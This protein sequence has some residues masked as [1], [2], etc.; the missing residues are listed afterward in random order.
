MDSTGEKMKDSDAA[1]VLEIATKIGALSF[2]EFTLTSGK[3]SPYYFDGRLLTLD[4]AGAYHVAKAFL[5]EIMICG[6]D[7]AAGPAVAAVP[8]VSALALL[9]HQAGRPIPALIVRDAAKQHGTGKKIEG[10][11]VP[12]MSVVVLDDTC[13]TGGSL[14]RA[15]Q[16]VEEAGCSV[17]KVM[18][19]LDRNEGGSEE[20]AKRGYDFF[21]LL[22]AEPNGEIVVK[23]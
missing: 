10:N 15:I 5:A 9:S 11:V 21:T 22:E 14:I 1:I 7:A 4:P 17:A 2:G 6:A 13:T 23:G 16:A 19:I 8:I 20:I 12:G 3:K 18:C